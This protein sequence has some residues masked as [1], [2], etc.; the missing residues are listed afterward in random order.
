MIPCWTKSPQSPN[1]G[2]DS[3][4]RQTH[5]QVPILLGTVL[6][7][8]R[9]CKDGLG[10]RKGLLKGAPRSQAW[11]GGRGAWGVDPA[12]QSCDWVSVPQPALSCARRA[13]PA[14]AEACTPL[15]SQAPLVW[16]LT[17]PLLIKD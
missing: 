9:A 1:S 3:R 14:S 6:K 10:V 4:S 8:P 11:P 16:F 7:L 2:H 13:A 5:Q 12:V 15:W 17:R